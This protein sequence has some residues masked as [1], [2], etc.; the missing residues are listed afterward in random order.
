MLMYVVRRFAYMLLLL[1]LV[2]VGSFVLI[3]L[4]PG[5]YVTVLVADME[6]F[7]NIVL[8]PEDVEQLRRAYGLDRPLYVQY[9]AWM[10]RLVRGDLGNSIAYQRPVLELL[11]E[12]VPMTV[13]ISVAAMAFV[14]AMA[15]PIGIYS[16]T[17][18]YSLGDYV[19][20][21]IGFVGMAVPPF[22]L[23]LV[24]MYFGFRWF[25]FAPAGLLSAEY[26]AEPWSVGKLVDLLK[27][28]PLPVIVTGIAGTAG[29]IRVL[30]ACLL[31]ELEQQYVVTAR[32]KGLSE[33]RLL[34]K[35]PVRVAVNPLVSTIGWSLAGIVSGSTIISIVLNLPTTGPLL[36]D[37]VLKQD[38]ELAGSIIMVLSGLTVLGTYLSDILLVL[39]D[40][41]IRY[42]SQT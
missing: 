5:D 33:G 41:R 20:T 16:A 19:V 2:S 6:M 28:L 34:M 3:Q 32:A 13:V 42:E 12:R 30:R 31:D 8:K 23:A 4:P 7:Q 38:M 9:F 35:Y 27:H 17:H 24:V 39:V 15:I 14:W 1:W 21:V 40:P 26:I 25:G 36:L 22:L 37:A 11:K 29:L 18:Q 10:G